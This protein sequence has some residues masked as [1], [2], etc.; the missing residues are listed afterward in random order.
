[1]LSDLVCV[2]LEAEGEFKVDQSNVRDLD[3]TV[4]LLWFTLSLTWRWRF[5]PTLRHFDC[6]VAQGDISV[7]YLLFVKKGIYCDEGN[8]Y[9]GA[10]WA[11]FSREPE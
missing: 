5:W 6:D 3:G 10:R 8:D 1:M 2:L 4:A 11:A 9:G 7:N